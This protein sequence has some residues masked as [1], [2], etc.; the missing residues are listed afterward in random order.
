MEGNFVNMI[1]QCGHHL[2]RTKDEF[3]TFQFSLLFI[4]LTQQPYALGKYIF[5]R[6]YQINYK[7]MRSF[8]SYIIKEQIFDSMRVLQF[9]RRIF[10]ITLE[11]SQSMLTFQSIT[12]QYST[13]SI[14]ETIEFQELQPVEPVL[15]SDDEFVKKAKIL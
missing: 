14:D 9:G 4:I 15:L 5:C 2:V 3:T 7:V 12:S 6:R 1:E 8:L 11:A 13:I 10:N